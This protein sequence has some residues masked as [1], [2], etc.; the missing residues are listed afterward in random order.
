M[1]Q[2]TTLIRFTDVEGRVLQIMGFRTKRISPHKT[3]ELSDSATK[4]KPQDAWDKSK[5]KNSDKY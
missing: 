2:K 1:T 4:R 3:M 5:I